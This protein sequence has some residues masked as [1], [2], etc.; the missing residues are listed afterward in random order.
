MLG[1]FELDTIHCGDN[2]ELCRQLPDACIDLTVTS[3][4]YGDMR[5]YNGFAWDFEG[6]AQHLYRVTKRGGVVVWVVGDTTIDGDETGESFIQALYFKSIGFKLYDTM[7][8]QKDGTSPQRPVCRYGANFEYMF[9]LSK[10]LPKTINIECTARTGRVASKTKRQK[11][12]RLIKGTY[13]VGGGP[14]PNVWRFAGGLNCTGDKF[15]FEH[16]APFPE[17]LARR[18]IRSWSNPGDVVLD[19][20]MGSGTVAKVAFQNGRHYLGF[21]ISQEYVDLARRRVAQS[22]PPLLVAA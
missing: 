6:I 13:N 22:N 8:Y 5:T 9:V 1:P 16:P 19:P 2:V 20:F 11:D 10:G 3:P 4:P 7:I 12:G 15:C 17:N 14:L 18:H 21:E